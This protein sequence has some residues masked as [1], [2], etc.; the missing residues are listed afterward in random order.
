MNSTVYAIAIDKRR[1][2]YY[3]PTAGF[4]GV[5]TFQYTATDGTASTP[6]TVSVLVNDSPTLDNSG[7]P[8]LNAQNQDDSASTG[9][10]ISTIIAN[11]GGTQITDP[12]ASALQGIAITNLD[13]TNG[14]WQYTTDGTTWNNA[15]AV[16]AT[17]ALLLASDTNTKIR[18]VPNPGYNGTLT[19][20]IAF[21]AWDQIVGTNGDV[22]DY[23]TDRT[24]NTTS[25]VF[26]SATETADIAINP[27][28]T[29]TNVSATTA[30]GTY[31]IGTSIDITVNFSQIVNVTGTP[32]LSLAG[33]T[34]FASYLSGSGSNTLT[35]RYAVAS[36]D[37]SPDLDYVS[38]TAL[39]LSGGTIKNAT[40]GDAI[41]TLVSPGAPNSL[42][43]SKAIVIDGIAP[44]VTLTPASATTVNGV[45]SV[46]ATFSENVTG[47]DNTDIT[48]TNATVGNFVTVDA[49]TY[50]FD[51]T[52]TADGNVTVDVLAAKA[53][54]TAG[55]NNTAA[56]WVNSYR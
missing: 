29:V 32:Q 22:A 25:S 5:D 47:F 13:T 28:P 3:T 2:I 37:I 18:F 54:D 19:N 4:N 8:T 9:T 45:F 31:G 51:V 26:S 53:T 49:K 56:T 52:P 44:T 30:D 1:S 42:G 38:T 27:L 50:T 36:G 21:A 40:N 33:V 6:T 23:T 34:P 55:N 35:F 14:T 10:L 11:L 48:V 15:P 12:N 16:T 7:I 17:N 46:T 39:S 20:A 24:N 41:L 43:A